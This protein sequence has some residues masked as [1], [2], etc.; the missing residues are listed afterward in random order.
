MIV[1]VGQT[2]LKVAYSGPTDSMSVLYGNGYD[3]CGP[4]RYQYLDIEG[5]NDFSLGVFGSSAELNAGLADDFEMNLLSERTGTTMIANATLLIDLELYPTSTPAIFQVNM[6][7]RECFP[8]Y[9]VG[10]DLAD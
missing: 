10:P 4:L 5:V 7:Y 9:F 8:D 1:P 3:K 6:T 2:L